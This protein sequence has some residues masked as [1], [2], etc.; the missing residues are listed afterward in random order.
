MGEFIHSSTHLFIHSTAQ[1]F[2]LDTSG[3]EANMVPVSILLPFYRE[4]AEWTRTLSLNKTMVSCTCVRE[5]N[6]QGRKVKA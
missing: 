2:G 1:G 4:E 3:D 5:E 6:K